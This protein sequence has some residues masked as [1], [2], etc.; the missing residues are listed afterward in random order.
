M[1]IMQVVNPW[2]RPG[3]LEYEAIF[4]LGYFQIVADDLFDRH[5]DRLSGIRTPVTH[6][7]P[8]ALREELIKLRDGSLR[9][10]AELNYE[11]RRKNWFLFNVYVFTIPGFALLNQLAQSKDYTQEQMAAKWY[12]KPML[13][14]K[15]NLSLLKHAFQIG[16]QYNYQSYK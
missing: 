9:K 4:S 16:F 14:I 12:K 13:I 7:D 6:S 5:A 2:L 10:F 15:A 11:D 1:A 3:D 8:L